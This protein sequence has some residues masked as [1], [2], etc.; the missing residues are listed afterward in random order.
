M[1]NFTTHVATGIVTSG[2]LATLTLAANMVTPGEVMT[3]VFAGALGAMLPDIDLQHSRASQALFSGLAVFIAFVILFNVSYKYSIAEMW[4]IWVGTYLVVRY[5][6]HA[7][8]HRLSRHR[9]IFH[10]VLAAVFFGFLTA[11]AYTYV[12]G[13]S[14]TL[15]WLAATFVFVGAMTHLVL[16]EIYS[17]DVMNER[18][19]ES[20]GSAL[21]LFDLRY[22]YSSLT[23]AAVTVGLFFLTPS[24]QSFIAVFGSPDVWAY[25]QERLLPEG[26]NWF[27]LFAQDAVPAVSSGS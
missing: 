14:E 19:K 5:V 7:L 10:S 3:L 12:F 21:K 18:V 23:L 2:V 6:G 24:M 17:V 16:D 8:F 15:S 11:I 26:S 27:G 1:A 13:A 25:F 20:F 22:P 4:I 9:G